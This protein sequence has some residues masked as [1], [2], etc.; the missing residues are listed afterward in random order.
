[1]ADTDYTTFLARKSQLY[2]DAGFA[3]HKLPSFLFDFQ[4]ALVDWALRKGRAAIFADCGLGKTPMQLVW[5]QNV[6]EHTNKSVL[7]L[8]PLAVGA[9]TVGEGE[10]FDIACQRSRDGKW[11][12]KTIVVTNYE[13][14]HL[15]SPEDFSGVVCDESSILKHYTGAT[16]KHVTRFLLK[17]PYRLLCTAT[18]APNDYTELGTSSEALGYL[19]HTD[20]LGRFFVL[21]DKK[22]HRMNDVKMARDANTG[23]YYA[24]LAY[25]QAQ[26]IG[27]WRMKPHAEVPFWRWV[28]SWAKACQKPSDLGFSD[29]GFVLPALDERD[30][31]I[32]PTTPPDGELFTL[33]AFGLRAERDERRRTLEQRAKYVAQLAAH[34]SPVVIWCHLNAEGDMLERMIPGAVQVKGGMRDEEKEEAYMR[35]VSGETRVLI[36]KP[37]IGAWGMNWQHCA[38]TI[39]FATH[40]YEQYYQ[41]IRRFWRFGQR[42]NVVVD[43][44][45]TT[46]EAY[47][48]E[49]MIRKREAAQKMF[50]M[51]VEHMS[52]ALSLATEQSSA[53]V[54]VPSWI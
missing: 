33:P 34:T 45:S 37:K 11:S 13:K 39:T 22:R 31:V 44:V 52:Q 23:N 5:G 17:I 4:A 35:F 54:R 10:K 51:I 12:G 30:H 46:G 48:R 47:V 26:M 21:S 20:M 29:E 25:R 19:G 36:I 7:I 3:P 32:E 27:A 40:S 43:I 15:F 1:M 50:A 14:L 28:G 8:T 18:A 6:L 49:N 41:A 2:P 42:R 53:T 9:Q 24:R 16:Q 38:H